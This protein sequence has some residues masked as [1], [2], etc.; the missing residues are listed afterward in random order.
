MDGRLGMCK[1]CC[2]PR[3]AWIRVS[4]ACS[5]IRWTCPLPCLPTPALPVRVYVESVLWSVLSISIEYPVLDRLGCQCHWSE[6]RA[7]MPRHT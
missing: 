7:D 3:T 6:V 4:I 2:I 1:Q 5:L